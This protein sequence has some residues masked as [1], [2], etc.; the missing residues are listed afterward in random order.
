M[1]T[2]SLLVEEGH[3]AFLGPY[4]LCAQPSP[5]HKADTQSISHDMGCPH[6]GHVMKGRVRGSHHPVRGFYMFSWKH[7]QFSY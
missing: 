4:A 6:A 7:I 1:R 5:N 2:Y 3:K